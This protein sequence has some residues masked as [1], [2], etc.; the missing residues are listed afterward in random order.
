MK[1]INLMSYG[2]LLLIFGIFSCSNDDDLGKEEFIS[3][4]INQERWNADPEISLDQE[5][6]SLTLLGFSI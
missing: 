6:D 3:A 5:N 2:L 4:T 1:K